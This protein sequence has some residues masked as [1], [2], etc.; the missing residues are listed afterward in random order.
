MT[1][2]IPIY[3]E[4]IRSTQDYMNNRDGSYDLLGQILTTGY[5]I[6]VHRQAETPANQGTLI[7]PF[8]VK[9]RNRIHNTELCIQILLN[10][11]L[12]DGRRQLE[13]ANKLLD[14][15]DIL[16]EEA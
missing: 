1:K 11:Q 7:H 9:A 4:D 16:L 2:C 6:K 12:M 5:G 10:S 14:E 13:E 3:T 15:Y 8:T